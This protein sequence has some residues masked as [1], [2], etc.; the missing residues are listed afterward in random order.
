VPLLL[1]IN[2][3][4]NQRQK[5]M[6]LLLLCKREALLRAEDSIQRLRMLLQ[7]RTCG[8]GKLLEK[9]RPMEHV[10]GPPD[11]TAPHVAPEHQLTLKSVLIVQTC[12]RLRFKVFVKAGLG[13][14]WRSVPC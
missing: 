4:H 10:K 2:H 11:L 12:I 9:A 13:R 7:M 8:E 14:G 1:W 5:I 6:V 3:N